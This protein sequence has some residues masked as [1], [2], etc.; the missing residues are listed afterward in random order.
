MCHDLLVEWR[1]LG[2]VAPSLVL[3][4][5]LRLDD[6]GPQP[7]PHGSLPVVKDPPLGLG[8][9]C[10]RVS[11]Q[12]LGHGGDPGKDTGLHTQLVG[13]DEVQDYFKID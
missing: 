3:P 8:P 6:V 4:A 7:P 12:A 5:E 13:L 9:V 1:P 2:H 10:V 11:P